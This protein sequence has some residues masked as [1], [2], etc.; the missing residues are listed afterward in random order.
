VNLI[1]EEFKI[2]IIDDACENIKFLI[3]ILKDD[4]YI[5]KSAKNGKEALDTLKS[6]TPD[7]ILLDII[8]PYM[9]GFTVCKKIKEQE[10]L[11]NIPIVF[12]TA[13]SDTDSIVKAFELGGVDYIT[14]PF[15]SL[16]V[17]ARVN[18]QLNIVHYS[19]KLEK[20]NKDLKEQVDIKTKELQ[21]QN[22]K[23]SQILNSQS[24]I[25]CFSDGKSLIQI[26][27]RFFN[28][29][30]FE[31][32]EEFKSKYKCICD[33]F[34]EKKGVKHLMPVMDDT[35][36]LDYI[37]QNKNL[38]HTAYMLDKF[39]KERAFDVKISGSLDEAIVVLTEITE[40]IN[41]NNTLEQRVKEEVEYNR[42]HELKLMEQAKMVSLGEMIGNIA[43]QW[44]QPLSIISSA[45]S[46]MLVHK[47]I[48]ILSDDEF[49]KTCH[50]ISDNTQYLSKT[51]DTFRDFVKED[52]S[53]HQIVLQ[54]R[55]DS[56]LSIIS[57]SLKGNHI[58]LINNIDYNN[59][60]KMVL[61]VGEL[62]QVIINI[63]N[64]AKD[65]LIERKIK[66]K[67]ITLDLN[68]LDDKIV[69]T[70]EDNG[71][72]ISEDIMPKIF[73]PYFTTKH[74][75]IGTGLGLH[76]SY[77]IMIESLKG[78]LYAKNSGLGAKFYIEL[79]L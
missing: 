45:T 35:M 16:E 13:L 3:N 66:D 55:I 33:L 14:K 32:L 62:D 49:E 26:N 30:D 59:P 22:E 11:K 79:P 2:L 63:L 9:D 51:I 64:N 72:G 37:N 20:Y 76:M 5:I 48:G 57:P 41:L 67:I 38:T 31:N 24:S 28:Y 18:A 69:L 47:E 70:I 56:I 12:I 68:I 46:G 74:Q 61:N 25:V 77:K 40:L 23:M 58:K 50:I 39:G 43:H 73:E 65:I 53:E 34:I 36:W 42:Q 7:L 8:M 17:K 60:L 4:N 10:Y 1:N 29:F 75:S 78:N 21:E 54:E 27:D 19:K 15:Q 52:K 71:G 44:R 6:F